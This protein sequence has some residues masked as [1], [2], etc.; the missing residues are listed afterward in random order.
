MPGGRFGGARDGNAQ[1]SGAQNPGNASQNTDVQDQGAQDAPENGR[2]S[3]S[4][5]DAGF[6]ES[7]SRGT[8]ATAIVWFGAS[9]LLLALAIVFAWRFKNHR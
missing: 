8:D 6:S 4:P 5:P 2:P 7:A 1:N 3:F 9:V